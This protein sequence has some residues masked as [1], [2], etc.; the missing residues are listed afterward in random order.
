MKPTY[1]QLLDDSDALVIQRED[2]RE[3]LGRVRAMAESDPGIP[4]AVRDFLLTETQQAP[5][6]GVAILHV[7]PEMLDRS[8]RTGTHHPAPVCVD[9][10][11]A[12][13]MREWNP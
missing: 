11:L 4:S 5:G 3:R 6:G 9:E 7:T 8:R 1:Q 13:Q 10:D 2:L 12:A